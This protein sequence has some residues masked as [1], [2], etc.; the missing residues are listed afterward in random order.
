M[1]GLLVLVFFF[2]I[3]SCSPVEISIDQGKT[4]AKKKR[5]TLD[6]ADELGLKIFQGLGALVS[7]NDISIRT[8]NRE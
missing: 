3:S 8:I 4:P 5:I 2:G 6:D 7:A 1:Q